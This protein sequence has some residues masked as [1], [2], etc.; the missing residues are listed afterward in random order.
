MAEQPVPPP[1]VAIG[2]IGPG[3]RDHGQVDPSRD[4]RSRP[5]DR[6]C[7]RRSRS[8]PGPRGLRRSS[9]IGQGGTETVP[10]TPGCAC[11]R[12]GRRR[13]ACRR[14]GNRRDAAPRARRI[15]RRSPCATGGCAGEG[16]RA[17]GP[18]GRLA[19]GPKVGAKAVA[20]VEQLGQDRQ[21][22]AVLHGPSAAD[23]R[24]GADWPRHRVDREGIWTAAT[25][26]F[27]AVH[28]ARTSEPELRSLLDR[29]VESV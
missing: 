27:T 2:E 4:N 28:L 22:H 14:P 12:S 13:R 6:S 10:R 18:A 25:T 24:L 15:P 21:L 19:V 29:Q 16:G 8:R 1:R 7:R 26:I 9:A 11:D 5:C 20:G 3:R 17:S 23:R